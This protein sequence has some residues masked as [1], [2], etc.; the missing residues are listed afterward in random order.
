MT[1]QESFNCGYRAALAEIT[2]AADSARRVS[3]DTYNR[4]PLTWIGGPRPKHNFLLGQADA[5]TMI[6]DYAH[7]AERHIKRS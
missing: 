5:L 7:S 1:D 2:Y 4:I 3:Q 6:I